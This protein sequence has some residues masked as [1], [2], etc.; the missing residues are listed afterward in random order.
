MKRFQ[1]DV[2]IFRRRGDSFHVVITRQLT[3]N[4]LEME[5]PEKQDHYHSDLHVCQLFAKAPAR[6]HTKGQEWS[7]MWV[8]DGVGGLGLC[9]PSFGVK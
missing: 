2:T 6:A 1:D 5:V 9:E 3:L 8:E 7:C 4:L